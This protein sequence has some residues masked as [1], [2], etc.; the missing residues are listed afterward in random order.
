MWGVSGIVGIPITGYA[1]DWFGPYG[2]LIV[3]GGTLRS[4]R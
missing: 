3:V 1:M 4:P 2:L